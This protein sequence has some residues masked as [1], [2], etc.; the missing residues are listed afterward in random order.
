MGL[1]QL[2]FVGSASVFVGVYCPLGLAYQSIRYA[3]AVFLAMLLAAWLCSIALLVRRRVL[4]E[5]FGEVRDW[6]C[7]VALMALTITVFSLSTESQF[8]IMDDEGT[9]ANTALSIY[10]TGEVFSAH[11]GY[12]IDDNFEIVDGRLDKR[13]WLFAVVVAAIH[14]LAGYDLS[15]LFQVNYVISSLAVFVFWLFLR[16]LFGPWIAFI[17]ALPFI[18]NPV[19]LQS[20]SGGGLEPINYFLA[21]VMGYAMLFHNRDRYG[22]TPEVLAVICAVLLAYARYESAVWV[23]ILGLFLLVRGGGFS[24]YKPS[25]TIYIASC[26]LIPSIWLLRLTIARTDSFQQGGSEDLPVFGMNHLVE[27]ALNNSIFLYTPSWQSANDFFLSVV[28]LGGLFWA[29]RSFYKSC[30]K[31]E[32]LS[33]SSYVV[34]SWLLGFAIMFLLYAAYF[35]GSFYDVLAV[36]FCLVAIFPLLIGYAFLLHGV[37]KRFRSGNLLLVGFCL[38]SLLFSLPNIGSLKSLEHE[39]PHAA[40]QNWKYDWLKQKQLDREMTFF[41]DNHPQ[42]WTA[43]RYSSITYEKVSDRLRPLA[44][45]ISY[46]GFEDVF[47]VETLRLDSNAQW[48]PAVPGIREYFQLKPAAEGVFQITPNLRAQIS[49]VVSVEDKFPEAVEKPYDPFYLP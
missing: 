7:G 22:K 2:A 31:K 32:P 24:R 49:S 18:W 11:R 34:S 15:H 6:L 12:W 16:Q 36:R 21:I 45:Q 38:L 23:I 19:W 39:N 4:L 28:G 1:W 14:H 8:G 27:N 42:V 10:E 46:G 20:A 43:S 37:S 48:Q 33:T 35:W 29:G 9:I 41:I 5:G 25:L 13:P 26:I 3:G 40:L 30:L 44:Y 47:L 17:A